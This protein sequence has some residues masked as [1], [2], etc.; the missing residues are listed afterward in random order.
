MSATE[1]ESQVGFDYIKSTQFRVAHVDGGIGGI[2][3]SGLLHFA[4]FSERPA[5]PKHTVHLIEDGRLGAELPQLKVSRGTVVREL[6]V[7]LIMSLQV[8]TG[9]RDWLD[10]Q[11]AK[12]S[13]LGLR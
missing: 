13:E 5:I 9:I 11:I 1:D 10:Q 4:V 7:D 3:P 12:A 8:A 6:E 2:T